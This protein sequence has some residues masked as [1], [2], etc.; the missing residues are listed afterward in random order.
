MGKLRPEGDRYPTQAYPK[1][2]WQR[3]MGT[4]LVWLQSCTLCDTG[5]L[6]LPS[7]HS[8]GRPQ[9]SP[10][11]PSSPWRERAG[12]PGLAKKMPSLGLPW[13]IPVVGWTRLTPL[14][15]IVACLSSKSPPKQ[16]PLRKFSGNHAQHRA[17]PAFPR[18]QG[19][20]KPSRVSSSQLC[21]FSPKLQFQ[22]FCVHHEL[23]L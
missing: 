1:S 23:S 12:H 3:R 10:E 9:R 6:A 18:L 8:W 4:R 20:Q 17:P 16:R 14:I 11:A 5:L 7:P 22:S 21:F 19:E 15:I 13:T 2:K